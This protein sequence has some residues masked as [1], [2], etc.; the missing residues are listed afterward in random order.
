MQR[1]EPAFMQPA[2]LHSHCLLLQIFFFSYLPG[3]WTR[4]NHTKKFLFF[5]PIYLYCPQKAWGENCQGPKVKTDVL[6]QKIQKT[7]LNQI[8]RK[9]PKQRMTSVNFCS[10][11]SV[12]LWKYK[13][14]QENWE[15]I[16]II[17]QMVKPKDILHMWIQ[18][19]VKVLTKIEFFGNTLAQCWIFQ[20]YVLKSRF[21]PS[22]K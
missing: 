19:F 10:I 8:Y 2:R 11:I 16:F 6:G 9:L 4:Q 18:T 17:Q 15:R 13:R 1:K 21:E 3:G 5:S 22:R 14:I 20:L 7:E 12:G